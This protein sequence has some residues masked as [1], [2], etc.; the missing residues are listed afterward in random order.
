MPEPQDEP[1]GA[2][3]QDLLRQ[4][5]PD[6][7]Q[8]FAWIHLCTYRDE[9]MA[10]VGAGADRRQREDL[11]AAARRRLRDRLRSLFA[12]AKDAGKL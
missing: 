12:W 6:D 11:V 2:E 7:V 1:V 10:A 5:M 4:P 8:Q 3:I 9:A